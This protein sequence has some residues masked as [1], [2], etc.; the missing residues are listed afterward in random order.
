MEDITILVIEPNKIIS[1]NI[2][3]L[4]T[5]LNHKHFVYSDLN[6]DVLSVLSLQPIDVILLAIDTNIELIRQINST[7]R[8]PFVFYALRLNITLLQ[9]LHKLPPPIYLARASN[10]E[11]LYVNIELSLYNY[12]NSTRQ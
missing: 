2:C 7:Y 10:K 12:A 9:E 5:A 6:D 1:T 11:D 8:I 3:T 4:L